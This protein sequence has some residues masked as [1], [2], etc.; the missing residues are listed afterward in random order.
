MCAAL[1]RGAEELA[2]WCD[3]H[4]NCYPPTVLHVTDGEST[5]G[6][7]ENAANA[8]RQFHTHDGNVLLLNLHVSS[9]AGTPIRFPSVE[10]GLPDRYAQMLFRMSSVLPEHLVR[11]VNERGNIATANSR[12]YIFNADAAE[13]VDFFDIGTRATQ[14]R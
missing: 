6:D 9:H 4:P 5:D 3:A 12:G 14:L 11:A 1:T 10:A 13:I 8:I 7:P 2:A